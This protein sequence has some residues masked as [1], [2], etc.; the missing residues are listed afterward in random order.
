MAKDGKSRLFIALNLPPKV[1][2]SLAILLTKLKNYD[3]LVKWCQPEGLHL[4]LHFLGEIGSQT[5]RDVIAALESLAGKFGALEFKLG[6][7]GAFP[8]L[9]KPKVIF[10]QCRQVNGD[11]VYRLQNELGEKLKQ[12]KL[13]V[14]FR[15]WRAHIT[16]GR[17]KSG[18]EASLPE[19]L[20]LPS[21]NFI[22]N[23]FELME[24]ELKPIGA[25]YRKIA[26]FKL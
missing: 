22:I 1:K 14:D 9:S 12:L 13:T 2:E 20:A 24:S 6:A 15:A 16:L 11:A 25:A 26:S 21:G 3:R 5:E 17:V 18:L 23:S 4:T 10:I 19:N 8:N 7:L